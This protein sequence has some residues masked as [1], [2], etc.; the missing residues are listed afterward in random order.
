MAPPTRGYRLMDF[1]R[2]E[3]PDTGLRA[4]KAGLGAVEQPLVYSAPEGQDAS[5]GPRGGRVL[6]AVIQRSPP[7]VCRAIGEGLYR[8]AA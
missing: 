3:F 4:F 8:Y 6:T 7:A 1:G 5:L 2:S